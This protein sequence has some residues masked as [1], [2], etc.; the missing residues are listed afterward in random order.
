M[1]LRRN[2]VFGALGFVLP[3]VVVLLAYPVVLRSLG[4]GAMGIY[5]LAISFSGTFAFLEFGLVTITTKLVAEASASREPERASDAIVT[6]LAFYLSLGV[7]GVAV[8]W[9]LSPALAGWVGAPDPVAGARAFRIASLLIVCAYANNVAGA[10]LKGLHRF[11]LAAAQATTLSAASWGGAVLVTLLAGG[12]LVRLT[13]AS[14]AANAVLAGLSWAVTVAECRRGGIHLASGRPRA[15]T[16]RAMLRFGIFMSLNGLM[17]V[18]VNQ[19][20]NVIIAR[21]LSPV[22]IAVWG[23]AVQVVSKINQLTSA[24][25]ELVLPLSAGL[26]EASVRTEERIRLLRS[27]YVKALGLS[28]LASAGASATL[29][30]LAPTVVHLWLHSPIDGEVSSVLRLLCIG[31]AVNG[32]TPVVFHLLNGIGRPEVNTASM[33][34]GTL[35]LYG[36]LYVISRSGITVER[37]AIATTTAFTVNGFLYIGYGELVVWRRWLLPTARGA[38]DA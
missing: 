24:A 22:A 29:Y 1:N 19:V 38:V 32:A 16:L 8:L 26:A 37:F 7:A 18:L 5:I 15:R 34:L 20:Q 14:L 27:V 17:G 28:F 13:G 6:S 36:T 21:L 33:A 9:S 11:D 3:T 31:I 4:A 25:F 23:T 10:V 2:T 35:L 12:G 30:A